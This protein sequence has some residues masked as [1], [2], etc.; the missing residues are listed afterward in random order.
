VQEETV[1]HKR[2]ITKIKN[3]GPKRFL[4]RMV[5][6]D[7]GVV[8]VFAL[9]LML[10]LAIIGSSATMTSQVD[11]KISGNTKVI[12][13]SFYVADGG[14][15]MTPKVISR[16]ITDRALPSASETP[17]LSYDDY[18]QA[19]DDPVLLKKIMGFAMDNDYQTNDANTTDISMDQGTLGNM[20]IDI[21]R[22]A[23][24]YLSGGGVE[25][26][27][28]TEGVGVGGA[29]SAAIIYN[30]ASR[31]TVGTPNKTTESDIIAQYR[32]V[33]GVAGGR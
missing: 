9:V 21:T 28:G 16:I 27:A 23:T 26:A 31:G 14:I 11:L 19:G 33:A 8:L 25:F 24:M 12:R 32:K 7:R 3:L 2:I 4:N 5:G 17:L 30:L 1:E 20:D 13:T 6:N 29:A 22:A 10:V 18:A 15:M